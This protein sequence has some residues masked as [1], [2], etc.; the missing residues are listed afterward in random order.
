MGTSGTLLY[1][2]DAGA[3]W[4]PAAVPTTADL[5]T[6]AT[7]NF[8]PVFIAG[9]GVFLMTTDTGAHWTS[10]PTTVSFRALAAAQLSDT[11]LAVDTAGSVGSYEHGS[12]CSGA[13]FPAPGP[14]R[15]RRTARPRSWSATS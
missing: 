10:I 3:T 9:N 8:G 7:Q 2:S 15:Y 4:K 13:A 11:V 6:L 12:S 1:T 14:S 5:R